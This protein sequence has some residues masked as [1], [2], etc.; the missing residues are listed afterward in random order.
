M[1]LIREKGMNQSWDNAISAND[2][3]QGA[4]CYYS[5]PLVPADYPLNEVPASFRATQATT[6]WAYSAKRAE[7]HSPVLRDR[8]CLQALVTQY[9]KFG[10][11]WNAA[12]RFP[13]GQR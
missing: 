4:P 13:T 9:K 1:I 8:G 12:E 3:S 11:K 2:V 10:W 6:A 5:N 7:L